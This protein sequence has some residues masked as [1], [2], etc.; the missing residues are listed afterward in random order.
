MTSPVHSSSHPAQI[1]ALDSPHASDAA[2]KPKEKKPKPAAAAASGHPLELQPPPEFF[3][4][5]IKMF[6]QLK[7]EY[8]DWVKAQP[9]QEITVTLPDGSERK[10]TS[11]ETSPMDIAKE[12]SK[13]LSERIVIAKVDGELW[14]LDRPL[15]KSV[16]LELLDFEH[17][18]GKKVF[19]HSSAH[20]L[21]E[22]AEKH[23]GCHLCLGPP[24]DDGFFYEMAIH[25]RPVTN[26]DY[27]AL[28]KL[29]EGA[30]KEKQKFERLVVSKEKLLEMFH[31]N[32]FKK[33]LI[34]TKVPDGTSTT[35]YRCGPMIDLCVGPHIPHTGKIKAMMV[36]KNSASYFLGD[37]N[38]E[39]LQR[40]YGISFPDKKQLSEYK[41]FLAEAAKRDHRKIGK[42]QELFFFNELS[43]GSC[44]F[45]PHGTRIYN[46]LVELMREEYFKRGYQEVISPNMYN[47]KLWE[48][49]G[50]WQNYK[51][52]MFVLDVEKEKWALKPMNCP[53]HC[54]I[55]DSR[56]RSYKEL[57]IRM[58]EFGIIHRNEASG[59]LTG[60]TRVRRFV[61]D[62]THVFCM[63]SQIEGE[64]NA[65]FDFMQHIYG[66]F[67]FEFHLELSTRPDN[68][69]GTVETWDTAEEQLKQ[70]LEKQY[71]G[72][73]EINPGDGAFYGPKIDITIRDALRRSFQC[74]TIQLDF[75]LPERFNLKYRSADEAA[76]RPVIIHRAILGSLER[77]I[78]IITEHFA[79]KWPFWLSPRQVLVIPVAAPY[80][81]YAAEITDRLTSLGLHAD[82]DNGENTL[83][84]KIRNGEIAQYNFILVVGQE[85]LDAKA[86]NVRNRDDVGS[87]GKDEMVPLEEA[88]SKLVSL[89]KTR[90]L[91]N[92]LV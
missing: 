57:P 83:S 13:S 14:D 23:Y 35:V 21:G 2:K 86:V 40:I 20:V 29:S 52:D 42:D 72:K 75:Q 49:S 5:R 18:E 65:L 32:K 61:Q 50:H 88:L 62:D 27:P 8:N 4:H 59:A 16:K 28:E 39:S 76:N 67:G 63:P 24:T 45:L 66:L 68:Y 85:E 82:V 30:V 55:F 7:T 41:V 15:E 78:A 12:V 22:A 84:K 91:E 19:W 79:G 64:I 48:T 25:D 38:N 80:K 43:P 6:E 89:K 44:F 81:A 47:S 73:W 33:Y 90:S 53:G 74:A 17:P 51:D 26:A 60:L 54:L 71:P 34:E 1:P 9:R 37:A 36:T 69:L 3:D 10:A 92:K 70:A 58:A 46:A 31:Y 77:F 87:K 11:W 56:D